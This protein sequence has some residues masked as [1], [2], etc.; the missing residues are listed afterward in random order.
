MEV[1]AD[2]AWPTLRM[3]APS[4]QQDVRRSEFAVALH[5]AIT[6]NAAVSNLVVFRRHCPQEVRRRTGQEGSEL[7]VMV[8]A[9]VHAWLVE[10]YV[11]VREMDDS[12]RRWGLR[13]RTGRMSMCSVCL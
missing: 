2:M 5:L 12:L 7:W 8:L 9:G 3:H 11:S 1:V 4:S 10:R 6:G 13:I